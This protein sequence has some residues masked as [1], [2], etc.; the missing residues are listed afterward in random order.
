M[1]FLLIPNQNQGSQFQMRMNKL[2]TTLASPQR[3]TLVMMKT[4]KTN[5]INRVALQIKVPPMNS[6]M[7]K[8]RKKEYD[9]TIPNFAE[10]CGDNKDVF[11]NLINISPLGIF[12][13]FLDEEI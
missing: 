6:Y 13:Y 1:S 11:A 12:N 8:W 7:P 3:I 9:H 5:Q 2:F 10:Y 4:L